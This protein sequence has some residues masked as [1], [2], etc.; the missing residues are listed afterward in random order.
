MGDIQ[1]LESG[2]TKRTVLLFSIVFI[3]V[4]AISWYW[5]YSAGYDQG[6]VDLKTEMQV[7]SN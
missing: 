4:I 5:G 3:V 1:I 7:N 6:Q 2:K